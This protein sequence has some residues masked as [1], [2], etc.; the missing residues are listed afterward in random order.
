MPTGQ[1]NKNHKELQVISSINR[2]KHYKK[3]CDEMIKAISKMNKNRDEKKDADLIYYRYIEKNKVKEVCRMI[4]G[5]TENNYRRLHQ[6][7]V[8]SFAKNYHML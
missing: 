4:I 2:G 7:A 5:L 6:K 8:V 3:A 1:S